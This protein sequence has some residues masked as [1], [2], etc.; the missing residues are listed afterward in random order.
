MVR[1]RFAPSPTGHLH[2]GSARTALFNWL[3]A[4][5]HG[6]RFLLRIEDTDQARSRQEYTDAIYDGLRWLGLDWDEV[7][8][9][10]SSRLD[11]YRE[12][13]D[14]LIRRGLAYL[15]HC[16]PEELAAARE[17]TLEGGK[18][19]RYERRC[20][21]LPESEREKR[22]QRGLTP[23]VRFLVPDGSTT[24]DD[25]VFGHVETNNEEV[26]DF[27]VLRGD[28]MP[29]YQ[30]AVVVDDMHMAITHV[31]RG[32]DHISNTP[33]QL[34]LYEALDE[35][36][37]RFAHLPLILGNDK[38][39]LSKRH[40][41][42]SLLEYRDMGYLPQAVLN[43]LALLGWSPGDDTE[44]MSAEDLVARF[45]L[46]GAG[47][48]DAVFDLEKLD[49][50]NGH[51]IRQC[52]DD[53]LLRAVRPFWERAGID[54]AAAPEERLRKTVAMLRVR[55]EKLPDFVAPSRYLLTDD[56]ETDAEAVEKQL[57]DEE[58]RR[59]LRTLAEHLEA[60]GDWSVTAIEQA[61]RDLAGELQIKAKLLIHPTRVA[62]TGTTA[63]P[64]L[65]DIM[66]VLGRD[67][68]V[69]RLRAAAQPTP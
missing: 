51:Y 21:D 24:F 67:R 57:A 46:A 49:W 62:L 2:V 8:L 11:D 3:F 66:D 16:T 44:L 22:L 14:G 18:P 41:A 55:A 39:R 23:A 1:V 37:P 12:R 20:V 30:L 61:L 64:S 27:V 6:G 50:M 32:A 28:G 36:A 35:Q 58:A 5:H 52:T 42:V 13:A 45:D 17:A 68:T 56:Y 34:L 59:R 15:C 29:T 48:R 33:K 31:I 47:K 54:V 69:A 9:H 7:P 63:G 25:L 26:E 4:R 38:K 19:S 53:D 43:F 10:Q 60:L 40:G 65:F